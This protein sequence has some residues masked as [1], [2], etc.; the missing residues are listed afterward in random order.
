MFEIDLGSEIQINVKYGGKEYSM[1]EP[2]VAE[3]E[4]FRTKEEE[5]A[6]ADALLDFLDTLGMPKDVVSQMGMSKAKKLVDDLM[7]LVTKKK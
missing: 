3:I 2:T 5:K 6:G 1:R 4:K 7:D